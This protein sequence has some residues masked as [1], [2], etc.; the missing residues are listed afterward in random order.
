VE[1]ASRL[2]ELRA[3]KQATRA[4]VEQAGLRPQAAFDWVL[5]VHEI[6]ANAIVHGN[7]GEAT[8]RVWIAFEVADE[9]VVATVRDEG[10]GFDHATAC[11]DCRQAREGATAS[12]RGLLLVSHLVDEIAFADSGRTVTIRKAIR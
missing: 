3:V 8:K 12:G 2:T 6:V 10:S 11:A 9:Q 5:A 1:I 7:R 4:F